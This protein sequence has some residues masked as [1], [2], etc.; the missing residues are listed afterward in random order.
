MLL[1]RS[2]R[3]TT[4][5]CSK[6][7][8][9]VM[10]KPQHLANFNLNPIF[11]TTV[12][13]DRKLRYS[14]TQYKVENVKLAAKFVDNVPK[15]I[16]PY[17]K[18]MRVDRPIGTWLLFWPCSWGISSAATAGS[19]PDISMLALFGAGAFV[20]RGAGCTI[21][22]MWDRDIDAKVQRTTNRPFVSGEINMK[23]AY[24]FL[25]GQLSVGL[26][27]LL[28]LNWYS[29]VLGASSL[30]LVITYPL[31]KR[32]THWPQLVLGFT[33][34]WGA[35]LGYSAIKN[36]IDYSVCLPLYLAGV[37]WTIIYDTIYAHQDR[38]DDLR[39][40]IKSTAIRFGDNTKLWLSGFGVAMISNLVLSGYMNEQTWPYYAAVALISTHVATQL[41]TLNI[42][43][44][45]DCSEKFISNSQIGLIL[46]CGILAGTFLKKKQN[47]C[48][49]I[50]L[51]N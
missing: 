42:N 10:L 4:N 23:Q 43:N 14:T 31:A 24:M 34:N 28:Q 13:Q 44:A 45:K 48:K 26:A 15:P 29:V 7:K 33:F 46:F 51:L 30:A 36:Y 49:T 32:F 20:M 19:L 18:L 47:D 50:Q 16:Q 9:E 25:F 17:L 41:A 8:S 37:C 38:N 11:K 1:V 3:K 22:D 21:N 35:L 2:L 27:I 40:G 6:Y 39:L 5:F 12:Y